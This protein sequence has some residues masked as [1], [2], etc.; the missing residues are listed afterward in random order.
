MT[1][2]SVA[3][4]EMITF[5]APA[6]R[7]LAA[8]SRFVNSP[9]DSITTSTP[10]IAPRQ[11]GGISLGEHLDLAAVDG[12]RL[13]ARLDLAREAAVDRVVLEQVGEGGRR[14]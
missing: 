10:E 6:S 14:R 11:R 12:D 9:V 8:S 3:G 7:C 4:A 1:S 2:G 5:F 13:L